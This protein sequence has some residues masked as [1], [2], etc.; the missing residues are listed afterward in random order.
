M[1]RLDNDVCRTSSCSGYRA[2]FITGSQTFSQV[3]SNAQDLQPIEYA[4]ME[5]AS[6]ALAEHDQGRQLA[7]L[8]HDIEKKK[9]NLVDCIEYGVAELE[10]QKQ[11]LTAAAEKRKIQL[12]A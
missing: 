7:E 3:N 11:Q 8:A 6:I 2:C 4:N 9:H 10:V 1:K 5:D 12:Y